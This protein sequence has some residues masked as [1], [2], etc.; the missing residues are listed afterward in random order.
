MSI[1]ELSREA[2]CDLKDVPARICQRFAESLKVSLVRR[3]TPSAAYIQRERV[4][5]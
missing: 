2:C 5:A 1:R 3:F 4:T